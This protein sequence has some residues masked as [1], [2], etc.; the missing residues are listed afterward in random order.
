[1]LIMLDNFL[2]THIISL[3]TKIKMRNSNI[4]ILLLKKINLI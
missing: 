1:M 2:R 3:T 4:K